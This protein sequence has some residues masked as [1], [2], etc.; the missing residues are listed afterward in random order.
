MVWLLKAVITLYAPSCL[1]NSIEETVF[2]NLPDIEIKNPLIS[3]KNSMNPIKGGYKSKHNKSKRNK[4][5]KVK[6]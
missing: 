5:R 2:K 3:N 6:K 1:P 4:S